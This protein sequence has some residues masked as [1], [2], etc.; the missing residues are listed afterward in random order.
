MDVI[1]KINSIFKSI[2][3]GLSKTLDF[4]VK[5]KDVIWVILV[6][7]ISLSLISQCKSNNKLEKEVDVLT[8]NTYALTDSIRHYHDELGNVIAE[9]HALQLTQEQMEQAIGELKKKNMEYVAYISTNMN[10][11]DTI[12]IEKIVYKDV[13]IDTTKKIE[14]GTIHLEKNETFKMS[15]RYI[16]ASIPYTSTYPTNLSINEA[17]FVLIQDIFVEGTI[18]RNTKT[19]ETILY[20][21]TDYPGLVFNSGNGIIPT[22]GKQYDLDMRKR[23]GIGLAVGPSIGVFYDNPTQ[24]LKAAFGVTLTIGY[25][26]TPKRFQW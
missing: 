11:N 10:M 26:F 25:T 15:K 1:E 18:A 3:T 9:K 12:Y 8:N 22:N 16:S 7:I 21:K 17:K 23:N 2:R 14:S 13:V 20:L 4:I 5:I 19:K 6:L 24:S